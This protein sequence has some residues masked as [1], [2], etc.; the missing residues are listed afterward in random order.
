MAIGIKLHQNDPEQV[1]SA[2]FFILLVFQTKRTKKSSDR[3]WNRK[4]CGEKEKSGDFL[5]I[6][7]Y[8]TNTILKKGTHHSTRL[9][10]FTAALWSV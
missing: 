3:N 4:D 9:A 1:C 10:L 7:L 5:S 2:R 6:N 8:K